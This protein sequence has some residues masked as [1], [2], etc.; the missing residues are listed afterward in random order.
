MLPSVLARR[1]EAGQG[2]VEYALILS[3][4]MLLA[5]A[6]LMFIGGQLNGMLQTIG[7]AF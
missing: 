2:L 1:S 7:N 6:A 5:V 3:L 4:I